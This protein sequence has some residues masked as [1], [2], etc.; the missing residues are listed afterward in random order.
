MKSFKNKVWILLFALLPV[1][2]IAQGGSGGWCSNNNYSRLFNPATIVELKGTIVTVEKIIPEKGMSNGI[3]L[4]LKT[5]AKEN[6]TVHLGPEWYLDNQDIL[7]AAGDK[8][9]IKG[10]KVT[11]ENKMAIIAMTVWKGDYHLDLRDAKGNPKWNGW[12]RAQKNKPNR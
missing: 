6:I 2:S 11:Y 9:K 8:I 5:E 3:H 4:V 7:F 10:S 1:I 12:K